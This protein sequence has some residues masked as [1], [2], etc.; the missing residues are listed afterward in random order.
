M[1][2]NGIQDC[3]LSLMTSSGDDVREEKLMR[4]EE[5]FLCGF[6]CSLLDSD[7][8]SVPVPSILSLI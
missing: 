4:E 2:K 6:K 7:F 5:R 1:K 3:F 8:I